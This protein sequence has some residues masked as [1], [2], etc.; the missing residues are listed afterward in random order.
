MATLPKVLINRADYQIGGG[1]AL[2]LRTQAPILRA[3]LS[4][5]EYNVSMLEDSNRA[6]FGNFYRD[7]KNASIP[8]SSGACA[9]K[10]LKAL[11]TYGC[12]VLR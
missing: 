9:S 2:R 3:Q 6:V 12:A 10:T 4:E 5:L 11:L 7:A 8:G 1:V